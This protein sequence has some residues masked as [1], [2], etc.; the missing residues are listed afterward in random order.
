MLFVSCSAPNAKQL[1][2]TSNELELLY[3]NEPPVGV[4]DFTV[5]IDSNIALIREINEDVACGGQ[6]GNLGFV[7][8]GQI[9]HTKIIVNEICEDY[10]HKTIPPWIH[11]RTILTVFHGDT[12]HVHNTNCSIDSLRPIVKSVSAEY[13]F[14]L[15]YKWIAYEF[16]H[17]ESNSKDRAEVIFR[18][19]FKGYLEAVDEMLINKG[20]PTINQSSEEEI[21]EVKKLYP[22]L[23]H[24]TGSSL[25]PINIP[26]N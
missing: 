26:V 18:E 11:F 16:Y 3:C 9:V 22:F 20:L 15:G 12:I 5:S 21:N 6:Q 2:F 25:L 14:D 24:L 10:T 23:F 7:I 17:T 19:I 1:F 13:Y 4:Y 8:G